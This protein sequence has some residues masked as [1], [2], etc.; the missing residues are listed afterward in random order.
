MRLARI[1]ELAYHA[2]DTGFEGDEPCDEL[3]IGLGIDGSLQHNRATR[4]ENL[5]VAEV[6][7]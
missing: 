5:D 3:L 1:V 4:H 2:I 7:L 6:R